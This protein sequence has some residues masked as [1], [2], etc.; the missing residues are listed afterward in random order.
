MFW[1]C[2]TDFQPPYASDVI[3]SVAHVTFPS[4]FIAVSSEKCITLSSNTNN[5][6]RILLCFESHWCFHQHPYKSLIYDS[7][8]TF[9]A[10]IWENSNFFPCQARNSSAAQSQVRLWRNEQGSS[11]R[12][13]LWAD[14]THKHN[15]CSGK[16]LLPAPH[17]CTCVL[18]QVL[19]TT[20]YPGTASRQSCK[21]PK[22][23]VSLPHSLNRK[24]KEIAGNSPA[25]THHF[26][27]FQ[28]LQ[29]PS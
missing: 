17:S 23:A 1:Q 10:T 18:R 4:Y 14:P 20:I 5:K 15:H 13:A 11:A 25:R 28:L 22:K 9:S 21:A 2:A 3:Y 24:I 12:R 7:E 8:G 26:G 16:G 27:F 6:K 29:V 19:L